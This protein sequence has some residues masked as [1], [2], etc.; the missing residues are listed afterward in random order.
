MPVLSAAAWLFWLAQATAPQ[1]HNLAERIRQAPLAPEQQSA[2]SVSLP[3][4]DYAR[5]AQ[6]LTAAAEADLAHAAELYALLGDIYF[7]GLRMDY[8]ARAL[9][10]ADAIAPLEERDRFTLAMALVELGDTAGARTQ[11]DTLHRSHP[12]RP[13]YL[14]WLARMDYDQRRYED[15]VARLSR[16]IRLDPQS[17]RAYDNLGLS[18]DMMGRYEEAREAFEKA[19]E[20]NRLQAHPSS[21]PP[22]NLGYLLLRLERPEEAEK[23]L[24]ESLQYDSR[25][26]MAHYHLGRVLET[27]GHDTAAVDQYRAA[28]ALDTTLAEPCYS[29]GLLYKRLKRSAEADAAFAEFR[30]RKASAGATE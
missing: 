26:A 21:W 18:L 5:I 1:P 23:A 22:H 19:A 2:I 9:R 16:V 15:S 4:K 14:Y 17:Y 24:R 11:L 10:R 30:R 29:L 13:L 3:A 6:L 12:E 7:V 8:A 20:L 27:E 25:F 28:I